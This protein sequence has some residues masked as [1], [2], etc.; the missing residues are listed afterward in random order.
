[1]KISPNEINQLVLVTLH[2]ILLSPLYTDF[3]R[4]AIKEPIKL[5]AIQTNFEASE[6][7]VKT[8]ALFSEKLDDELYIG[9]APVS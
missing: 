9:V 8:T 2:Y 1:M 6:V 5:N 7:T 3:Y 4:S